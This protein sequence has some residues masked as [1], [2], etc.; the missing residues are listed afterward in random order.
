MANATP[1]YF[2]AAGNQCASS[3]LDR[4]QIIQLGD[5]GTDAYVWTICPRLL[6]ESATAGIRTRDFLS[7]KSNALTIYHHATTTTRINY[8]SCLWFVSTQWAFRVAWSLALFIDYE[9]SLRSRDAKRPSVTRLLQT[10]NCDFCADDPCYFF[11]YV[12]LY[13]PCCSF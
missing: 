2:P 8:P 5:K 6:P 7:P 11:T 3:P 1:D 10:A 13:F 12:P 9:Y 4:Y